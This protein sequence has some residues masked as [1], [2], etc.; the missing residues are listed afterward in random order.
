MYITDSFGYRSNIDGY[1]ATIYTPGTDGM[2]V[3][4]LAPDTRIFSFDYLFVNTRYVVEVTSFRGNF[5]SERSRPVVI[6]TKTPGIRSY[7]FD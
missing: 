7:F 6:K 2:K 5:S 1:V 3:K 4:T